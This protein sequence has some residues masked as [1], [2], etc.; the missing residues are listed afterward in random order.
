[1]GFVVTAGV[2]RDSV[3]TGGIDPQ[4]GDCYVGCMGHIP[5]IAV[6]DRGDSDKRGG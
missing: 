3:E 5:Q 6:E 2:S 1:M 4:N